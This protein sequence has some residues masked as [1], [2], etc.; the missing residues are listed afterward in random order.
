MIEWHNLFGLTLADYFWD[1]EYMVDVEKELPVKQRVDIVIIRR[2]QGRKIEEFPDGLDNLSEHNLI[3]YKSIREPL[4]SWHLDEL[5]GHYVNYRKS[6]SANKLMSERKFRLYAVSTREPQKLASMAKLKQW[7]KGVY[8]VKWGLHA[9]RV[10]VLSQ[11]PRIPRNAI[12]LLFSALPENVGYGASNYQWRKRKNENL[13]REIYKTYLKEGAYMSYTFED[14]MRDAK[15]EWIKE[16]TVEERLEGLSPD[17]RLRGLSPDE[18]LRGLSPDDLLKRLSPDDLLK[19]L[20][21]EE[22]EVYLKKIQ[23]DRN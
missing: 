9:I 6:V 2:G 18:R 11:I 16:F 3:T 22:I 20:S 8:E 10:I 17:E 13:L 5:L 21:I 15:K 23:K 14:F 12:W 7:Q 1:S 4:T 19:R